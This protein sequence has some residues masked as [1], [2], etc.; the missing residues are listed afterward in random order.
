M[1]IL[2]FIVRLAMVHGSSPWGL[3]Q[4]PSVILEKAE[5]F[6]KL[7]YYWYL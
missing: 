6:S 7:S 2:D 1:F 3:G 4:W 5:T